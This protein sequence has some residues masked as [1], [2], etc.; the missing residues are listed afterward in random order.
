M[1]SEGEG[2]HEWSLPE[3]RQEGRIAPED[4]DRFRGLLTELMFSAAGAPV[5]AA[6]GAWLP[7]FYDL[8]R[9][10]GLRIWLPLVFGALA[11]ACIVW[12]VTVILR[13][14]RIKRK[15]SGE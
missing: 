4:Q 1:P 5:F 8:S 6:T 15:G 12:L 3:P 14:S 11:F 2:E 10:K 13:L 9:I 7:H